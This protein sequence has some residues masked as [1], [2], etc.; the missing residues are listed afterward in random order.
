M[1]LGNDNGTE[2]LVE[3]KY[4]LGLGTREGLVT[5]MSKPVIEN[6]GFASL[7]LQTQ[8]TM[9]ASL[10]WEHYIFCV[11]VALTFFPFFLWKVEWVMNEHWVLLGIIFFVDFLCEIK[12]IDL[13]SMLLTKQ[14]LKYVLALYPNYNEKSYFI[15][16]INCRLFHHSPAPS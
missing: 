12:K 10:R 1:F 16:V 5:E 8:V 4:E 7:L 14:V 15:Q 9:K 3:R 13:L 6:L 11:F 2:P